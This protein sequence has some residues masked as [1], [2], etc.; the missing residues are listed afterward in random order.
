MGNI[1]NKM[2]GALGTTAAALTLASHINEQN[3]ANE[4]KVAELQ[5][6]KAANAKEIEGAKTA[7]ANDQDQALI[8]I[9]ANRQKEL[10]DYKATF[11]DEFDNPENQK[12]YDEFVKNFDKKLEAGDVEGL[13]QDL[14]MIRDTTVKIAGEDYAATLQN[15]EKV[16]KDPAATQ[17]EK[18]LAYQATNEYRKSLQKA[19]KRQEEVNERIA[20]SNKL[21]FDVESRM[22]RQN[23]LDK[24]MKLLK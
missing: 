12:K 5:A 24:E 8:A 14:K 19:Y 23:V 6:E 1:Q 2:N 15:E 11:G 22:A 13:R 20:T 21:K 4:L 17:V 10:D 7:Y 9:K 3:K 16:M 18:N